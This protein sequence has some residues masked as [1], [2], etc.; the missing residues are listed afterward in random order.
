MVE[1][2]V[3]D[4]E[5]LQLLLFLPFFFANLSSGSYSLSNDT[6]IVSRE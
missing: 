6:F 1:Q 3:I 5:S 2:K 4:T